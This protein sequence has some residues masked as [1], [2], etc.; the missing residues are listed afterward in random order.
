MEQFERGFFKQIPRDGDGVEADDLVTVV[1]AQIA[2][3]AFAQLLG[4]FFEDVARPGG[5][6]G[7]VAEVVVGST[8]LGSFFEI[9]DMGFLIVTDQVLPEAAHAARFLAAASERPRR[10][11]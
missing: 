6:A 9:A 2:E 4:A 5:L 11:W 3:C 1:P 8:V 7:L 10:D